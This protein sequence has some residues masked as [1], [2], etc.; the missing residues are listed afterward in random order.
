MLFF[1]LS[2]FRPA[3]K[4]FACI[5]S[6]RSLSLSPPLRAA[7]RPKLDDDRL[8]LDDFKNGVFLAPMV[9][10]GSRTCHLLA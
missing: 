3:E 10:S 9:R 8:T 2:K 7:K 6:G 4:P 1:H 5:M